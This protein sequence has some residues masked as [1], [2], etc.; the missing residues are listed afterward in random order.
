MT[1][2]LKSVIIDKEALFQEKITSAYEDRLIKDYQQ[3]GE[4]AFETLAKE[5][6]ERYVRVAAWLLGNDVVLDA[7]KSDCPD[8]TEI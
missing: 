8:L 5:N 7:M 3:H 2:K 6:P 1:K 4:Q